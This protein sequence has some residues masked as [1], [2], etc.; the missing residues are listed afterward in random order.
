[1]C[2][3]KRFCRL[4][5]IDTHKERVRKQDAQ[6]QKR[7]EKINTRLCS[8]VH[9]HSEEVLVLPSNNALTERYLRT[10][11]AFPEETSQIPERLSFKNQRFHLR[12]NALK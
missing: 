10:S 6:R 1:M 2:N 4:K 9:K 11:C 5:S 12:K 8:L 7:E 3:G